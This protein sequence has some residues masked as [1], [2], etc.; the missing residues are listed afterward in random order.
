MKIEF[1]LVAYGV[2]Q[3]DN[4]ICTKQAALSIAEQSKGR[5]I[6]NSHY[7]IIDIRDEPNENDADKGRI[8]AIAEYIDYFVSN[9]I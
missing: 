6:S 7:K 8:I 3:P 9:I 4:S 5:I 2:V 1:V